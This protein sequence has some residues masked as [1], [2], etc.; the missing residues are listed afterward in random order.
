MF[1]RYKAGVYGV[2]VKASTIKHVRTGS[3]CFAT[4]AFCVDEVSS[5]YNCTL[6][7]GPNVRILHSSEVYSNR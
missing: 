7:G 3:S 2:H 6:L 5:Y 1:L 4:Q